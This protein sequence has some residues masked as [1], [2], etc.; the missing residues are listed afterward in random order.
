MK[1]TEVLDGASILAAL[2]QI[3]IDNVIWLSTFHLQLTEKMRAVWV[4]LLNWQRGKSYYRFT[5]HYSGRFQTHYLLIKFASSLYSLIHCIS[6]IAR[7]GKMRE[8]ICTFTYMIIKAFERTFS[9]AILSSFPYP[10]QSI[11]AST[12]TCPNLLQ[13]K[14]SSSTWILEGATM[15]LVERFARILRVEN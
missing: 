12:N 6:S 5:L 15:W 8:A 14:G 3:S 10:L 13:S 7:A 11:H 9:W 1:C 2:L 4:H